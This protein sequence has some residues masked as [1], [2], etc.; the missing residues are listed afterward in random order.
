MPSLKPSKNNSNIKFTILIVT[1][2]ICLIAISQSNPGLAPTFYL[3]QESII[4]NDISELI[5]EYN[6]STKWHYYFDNYGNDTA[7]CLNDKI[8]WTKKYE[9]NNQG[10]IISWV[11]IDS[12]SIKEYSA[13]YSYANDD[14]YL[15]KITEEAY[16]TPWLSL[17]FNNRSEIQYEFLTDGCQHFYK[18]DSV[19]KLIKMD[20][21]PGLCKFGVYTLEYYY[22]GDIPIALRMIDKY[23][24]YESLENYYYD[25]CGLL[26]RSETTITYDFDKEKDFYIATYT[27]IIKNNPIN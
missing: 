26:I 2:F 10:R 15:V 20:Y 8:L 12:N 23:F 22:N 24:R 16:G 17:S 6:D 3:S 14:S 18:Y 25:N 13:E 4:K 5:I 9:R 27:Y 11:Q 1:K 21:Q 19:G 7:L